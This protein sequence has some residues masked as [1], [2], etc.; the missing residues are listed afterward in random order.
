V[1]QATTEQLPSPSLK[2]ERPLGSVLWRVLL[3]NG[4]YREFLVPPYQ[5]FNL[6]KKNNI[7]L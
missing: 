7:L 6:S 2:I 1:V 5:K 4:F 3:L